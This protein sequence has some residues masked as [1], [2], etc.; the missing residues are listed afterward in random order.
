ML[1]I[2]IEFVKS[3]DLLS[4]TILRFSSPKKQ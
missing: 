2:D 4:I 3:F 1:A